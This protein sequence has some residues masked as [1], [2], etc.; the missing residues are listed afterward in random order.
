MNIQNLFT[1]STTKLNYRRSLAT[2]NTS[3]PDER[4]NIF[5]RH[6]SSDTARIAGWREEKE[7]GCGTERPEVTLAFRIIINAGNKQYTDAFSI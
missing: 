1:G 5:S 4:Y 3:F 7:R 2:C 6:T